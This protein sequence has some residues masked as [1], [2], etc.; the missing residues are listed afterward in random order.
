MTQ[1]SPSHHQASNPYAELAA[2]DCAHWKA[3]LARVDEPAVAQLLVEFLDAHP[4]LRTKRAGTYLSAHLTLDREA[5]RQQVEEQRAEQAFARGRHLGLMVRGSAKVL[6]RAFQLACKA[7]HSLSRMLE[8]ALQEGRSV[9]AQ[10]T[11]PAAKQEPGA[12]AKPSS[13]K[14]EPVNVQPPACTPPGAVT[15]D[16]PPILWPEE[17]TGSAA[18]H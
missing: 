9:P 15:L 4:E 14:D 13:D 11:A 5:R 18:F 12:Q 3:L 1:S 17:R 2:A 10:P 16:F 8:G 6:H 7:W